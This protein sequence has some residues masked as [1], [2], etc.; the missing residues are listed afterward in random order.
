MASWYLK[1]IIVHDL[2][3][4]E[5]SYFICEEWL[6]V[7][8][9]DGKIERTIATAGQVQKKE[10]RYLLLKQA[11]SN[12]TD[13]Y[14]WFSIFAKP[15]QSSLTRMDRTTNCFVL[16]SLLMLTNIMYY[17]NKI[18]SSECNGLNLGSICL[19]IQ[20]ILTSILINLMLFV[21]TFVIL[22]IFKRSKNR[23][24]Y[25]VKL[26]ELVTKRK[27]KQKELN[28]KI[29]S[30]RF[31]WWFK[32]IGYVLSV[33]IMCVSLFFVI[34]YG[35]TLGDGACQ[36][37]LSSIVISLVLSVLIT[38]PIKAILSAF[39]FAFFFRKENE[40]DDIINDPDDDGSP[41]NLKKFLEENKRVIWRKVIYYYAN[42]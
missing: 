16:L 13:G 21:P 41:I 18:S 27:H 12:I 10:L 39:I 2:Q 20:G 34:M 25:I 30:L 9:S 28:K 26:R 14:L 31:P 4:R 19:S 37:W 35:I 22:E 33:L 36:K 1:H 11:K 6:A 29:L 38:G 17:N 42:F 32:I 40:K 5:K 3:T 24:P 7:E 8:K 23:N 15:L